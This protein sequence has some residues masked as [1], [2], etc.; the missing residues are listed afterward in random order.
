MADFRLRRYEHSSSESRTE[1]SL[2]LTA[3]GFRP[4]E[5][6]TLRSNGSVRIGGQLNLNKGQEIRFAGD[7][8]IILNRTHRILFRGSEDKMEL[9]VKGDIIFSSGAT[10]KREETKTMMIRRDG[11][12]IIRTGG[13]LRIGRTTITETELSALRAYAS[14][15][16]KLDHI[17]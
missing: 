7:G 17:P 8:Q 13:T 12:V 5:I 1:L 15:F 11:Q 3:G 9:R 6:L 16:N 2:F 4:K 10:D 14:K